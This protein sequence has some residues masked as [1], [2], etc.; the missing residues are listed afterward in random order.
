[1]TFTFYKWETSF[2]ISD[3]KD[4]L[5]LLSELDEADS[6]L[7]FPSIENTSF[8]SVWR[9]SEQDVYYD[10]LYPKKVSES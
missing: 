8:F 6:C 3:G 9:A 7:P 1:M 2:P 5:F 4:A 10:L